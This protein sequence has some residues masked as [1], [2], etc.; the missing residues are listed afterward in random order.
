[1]KELGIRIADGNSA[2][3]DLVANGKLAMGMVDTDDALVALNK[4][5][6]VAV[7]F[8]DQQEPALGTLIIPNTVALIAKGP[9]PQEA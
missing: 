6:P 5:N 9:H 4:G 8:L 1:M 2:V 3:K 7:V